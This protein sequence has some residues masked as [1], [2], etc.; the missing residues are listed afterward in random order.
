[1]AMS[2]LRGMRADDGTSDDDPRTR[3]LRTMAFT[4]SDV[5]AAERP[6]L[7]RSVPLMR[8]A[9]RALADV[10]RSVVNARGS[11]VERSSIVILAGAGNNGG[12]G[13]YAGSLLARSG[14]G[15]TVLAVGTALHDAAAR[16][17]MRAGGRVLVVDPRC[18]MPGFDTGFDDAELRLRL[19]ASADLLLHADVVMDAMTGIGSKGALTGTASVMADLLA[20]ILHDGRGCADGND[21]NDGNG[22]G[23]HDRPTVV[24]VDVPSGL[25]V[26]SGTVPGA[27]ITADVTVTFGALKPCLVVPP[28]C[29]RR[30]GLVVVDLGLDLDPGR[31]VVRRMDASCAS[32]RLVVPGAGDMKYSRGV[33]G[34][35]TGSQRYPGAG[36]LSVSAAARSGCGMARYLGP[37]RAQDLVLQAMPEVVV[38]KGHVQAWTVGCGVDPDD[39]DDDSPASAVG[40]LLRHYQ[41]DD[42][43]SVSTTGVEPMPPVSMPPVCVD[44][45]ALDLLPDH[46]LPQVVITPHAG[47]LA[48]LLTR[49]GHP[50]TVDA[51]LD[52][53]WGNAVLAHRIT[54]AT[55]LLK[56]AMTLVVGDDGQGDGL[57]PD[58]AHPDG[59]RTMVSGAG[60]AWLSTA[61]SGDVLAG[62]IGSLLAQ[63]R[64]S[65]E[66]ADDATAE[67]RSSAGKDRGCPAVTEIAAAGA[68]IHG[69]SGR[70]ASG[71]DVCADAEP[72]IMRVAP[73][74]GVTRDSSTS[75]DRVPWNRPR[76][77][78]HPIVAS[79][80]IEQL[81]FVLASLLRRHEDDD[82]RR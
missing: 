54:G 81:Q 67:E 82:A 50:R 40:A 14:A 72:L 10:C 34:L 22:E 1:M 78:G 29:Y 47:E 60:P 12:D 32:S 24:A 71:C 2:G 27:S 28:A 5:R 68:Y 19:T 51:V 21:D 39:H 38:G 33:V 75:S 63:W 73:V 8:M 45:G 76:S 55:V 30:G 44:A 62:L 65:R 3:M 49:M 15:V 70:M 64:A 4:S 42:G 20:E 48:R 46:V 52:D 41:T 23:A 56:G 36:V 31:A 13:L 6:L 53:P 26:D 58:G 35:I 80:L 69:L 61:G 18:R 17:L 59:A 25:G 16:S 7:D 9:S 43:G 66:S 74:G 57:H 11:E 79:D 37:R 77:I